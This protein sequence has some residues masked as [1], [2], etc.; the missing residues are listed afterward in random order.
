MKNE[1]S[2]LLPL[3]L[4]SLVH[5]SVRLFGEVL[6]VE[7]GNKVYQQIDGLR[8]SMTEL[9]GLSAEASY[10]RLKE[11]YGGLSRL[12]SEKRLHVARAFTLMLE[13]MNTHVKMLI[14]LLGCISM[15]KFIKPRKNCPWIE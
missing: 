12:S 7:V 3:A 5:S 15:A 4:K 10:Q 9:R 14:E 13:I 1:A 8:E 11:K 2:P 6:K